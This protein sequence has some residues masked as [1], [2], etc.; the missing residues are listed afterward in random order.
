MATLPGAWRYRVNT[1]TGW[2][3][4]HILLSQC[5]QHVQSFEQIRPWDTLPCC[6]DVKQAISKQNKHA[7]HNRVSVGTGWPCVSVLSMAEPRFVLSSERVDGCH[8]CNAQGSSYWCSSWVVPPSLFPPLPPFP[9]LPT[10]SLWQRKSALIY[11][12]KQGQSSMN[13]A[14]A[15]VAILCLSDLGPFICILLVSTVN[16]FIH[17]F[18]CHLLH[19]L[20]RWWW[21]I[22][23]NL[24]W[25]CMIFFFFFF[26]LL[27]ILYDFH[28]YLCF[29]CH[30]GDDGIIIIIIR[31]NPFIV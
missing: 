30:G 12:W 15:V 22:L 16:L 8:Q 14:R 3:G 4:V 25:F 19:L 28:Y 5:D 23:Y 7:W 13:T 31:T 17:S 20:W 9:P 24:C 18:L 11:A 1:G 6:W 21:W 26:W 2:S 27:L 10:H 29:H